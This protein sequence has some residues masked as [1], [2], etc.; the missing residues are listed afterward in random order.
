MAEIPNTTEVRQGHELDQNNLLTYLRANVSGF[1]TKIEGLRQF[2]GGQSNP[3]FYLRDDLHN[4]YVVRKKPPGKLLASAHQVDREYRIMTALAQSDVPVPPTYC[5]CTDPAVIGTTFYVCKYLRG[6]VLQDVTLAEYPPHVRTLMYDELASV[7]ARIARVDVEK[8]GLSDYGAAGNYYERQIS[9]WAKQYQQ[10]KFKTFPS[11]D[12]LISWLPKNIPPSQINNKL[13]HGDYRL[14][15]VMFHPTEPKIIAVL[16]WELSTLG[17]PYADLAYMLI[18]Y[19]FVGE[20]GAGTGLGTTAGGASG[21]PDQDQFVAKYCA[22][23]GILGIDNLS[24]H[25]AFSLFRLASIIAGVAA[26]AAAGNASSA[27][28]SFVGSFA[29]KFADKAYEIATAGAQV[30]RFRTDAVMNWGLF[31]ISDRAKKLHWDLLVFMN[32]HIY[33]NEELYFKQIEEL[34]GKGNGWPTSVPP[35][36]TQLQQ[37]A[38]AQG[39]WNLFLPEVSGLSNLDYAPLCEVMGRSQ[40]A[41]EVFN[42]NAPDTGN[43]E[44]LER[45]GN[46]Q[47]KEEWLKPLLA[48]TIRSC[49]AMTEPDVA[50]SD[51][52][53]IQTSIKAEGDSYVI[54]G[55]KWYITN[56]GHPHCKIIILMGKTDPKASP[57]KQQSMVL[58]PMNTPGVELIRPLTVFGYDDAPS[59]HFRMKFT[60]VRVPKSNLIW[61]EGKGFEI[62]QGRLGPG[63][64]HHCMR[65]IGL[66]ERSHEMML[67]RVWSRQTFGKPIALHGMVANSVAQNR[68]EIDQSRLAVMHTAHT[69]DLYGNKAA[70]DLIA[71]IKVVVPNMACRVI[72]RVIQAFGAAG[73]SDE[74]QLAGFYAGARSLRIAD[75]P[76]EVHIQTMAKME[77][78]K[79]QNSKF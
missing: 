34:R 69:I 36:M 28:A 58:V 65:M 57:F 38:K 30:Q 15:N 72:D 21:I 40:L 61:D 53:N 4:E 12:K 50:S 22:D 11:M 43:M 42:C 25:L 27:K 37:L 64:I 78:Q 1:G 17:H 49:F 20:Y 31:P 63:R 62:A 35:I 47:Q 60:N 14:N 7:L 77:Y 68:A 59:G 9:R 74:F 10:S 26:R 55:S 76:D 18:P 45:Y 3:T 46:A 13:V 67:L 48:G 73:L 71:M 41:P 39:L 5:L 66:S 52:Q 24:F 51:A 54:N 23:L 16:D 70:R 19:Q 33:P 8:L 56:A 32:D 2:E 29:E 79:Y 75:G 44:V 6:R